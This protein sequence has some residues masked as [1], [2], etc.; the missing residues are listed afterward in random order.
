MRDGIAALKEE[1]ERQP[2]A[3][4]RFD[5]SDF[6]TASNGSIFVG[7]GDSFAAA[8]AA[9]Y[10]SNGHCL[11]LDPYSLAGAPEAAR[12]VHVYMVSVSGSTSANVLAAK[13]VRGLASGI[14]AITARRESRLASL[15]DDV[16]ELP[17]TYVPRS[18]GILSFS[19]SLLAALRLVG[20]KDPVD[21]ESALTHAERDS[22]KVAPGRGTTYI[23]GNSL[24]FPAAMYAAAKTYEIV[25][26]RAQAELLEEFSH[27][28]LFSLSKTD[29]VNMFSCFDPEGASAK[30]H[31]S[32]SENGYRSHLVPCTGESEVERLFHCVFVAQLAAVEWGRR[33]GLK[34]PSFLTAG[35]R[36][37]VSDAMI[38]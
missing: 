27:M 21:F 26:A 36:L 3:L 32:L 17:M 4:K 9:F 25:G 7:A 28:E 1:T 35:A 30:L 34:R 13:K 37:R 8:L 10:A 18:S 12:G 19:L 23:L 24:A 11:A 15:T 29:S 33:A 31:R 22:R 6:A 2:E 14:T 20:R 16:V 5:R 38:Y